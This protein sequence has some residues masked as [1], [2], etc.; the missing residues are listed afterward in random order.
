MYSL[1]FS[2]IFLSQPLLAIV[3]VLDAG[4]GGK[5]PGYHSQRKYKGEEKEINLAVVKQLGTIL[6][7][8][9]KSAKIIYTRQDDTFY[10]LDRRVEIANQN[11]ADLFISIHCNSSS[12][13]AFSGFRIHIH[14][15]TLSKDSQLAKYIHKSVRQSTQRKIL[16]IQD[17]RDR[18]QN[19]QI[20]QY[21]EMPSLLIELGFLSNRS[22]EE[23]LHTEWGQSQ[24]AR[25]IALGIKNF[26]AHE[27][28]FPTGRYQIYKIQLAAFKTSPD[29][30]QEQR[31]GILNMRL[32]TY[33]Q[34]GKPTQ[35]H[36]LVGHYHSYKEA[37]HNLKKIQ[38]AGFKKAFIVRVR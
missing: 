33:A 23:F 32:E 13:E 26:L 17:A 4:H 1:T 9:L 24:L 37:R 25:S 19:L 20:I 38:T 36:H 10:T 6:K 30:S 21:T 15:H 8:Q 18:N 7:Q 14:N 2:L 34:I 16:D 12:N 22:D 11:L 29:L 3:I 27:K 31:Q 35:F 28:P 5:D